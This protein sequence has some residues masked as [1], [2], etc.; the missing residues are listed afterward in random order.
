M[1]LINRHRTTDAEIRVNLQH[2]LDLERVASSDHIPLYE[3]ARSHYNPTL[4]MPAKS[5]LL[6]RI[7]TLPSSGLSHPLSLWE[8]LEKARQ[9]QRRKEQKGGELPICSVVSLD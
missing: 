1:V 9:C 7:L 5:R 3:K 6:L 4:P 2:L 8:D